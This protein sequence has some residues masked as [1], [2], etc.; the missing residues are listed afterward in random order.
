MLYSQ[1]SSM[2]LWSMTLGKTPQFSWWTLLKIWE[3]YARTSD[4]PKYGKQAQIVG[5]KFVSSCWSICYEMPLFIRCMY[6]LTHFHLKFAYFVGS[7]KDHPRLVFGWLPY[8]GDG[9]LLPYPTLPPSTFLQYKFKV[10]FKG[11]LG[12]IRS[13]PSPP[14]HS[15]ILVCQPR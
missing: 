13:P 8:L 9:G 3:V 4:P 7:V 6:F 14:I 10:N 12:Q 1:S 15:L 11:P 5:V 2:L